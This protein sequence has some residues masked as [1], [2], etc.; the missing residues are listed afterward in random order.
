MDGKHPEKQAFLDTWLS[1]YEMDMFKDLRQWHDCETF[2]ATVRLFTRRDRFKTCSLSGPYEKEMHPMAKVDLAKYLDH[3]K[4]NRKVS[5]SP[6]NAYR[7]QESMG[8]V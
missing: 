2:D 5:G 8:T 6:E 3:A 1:W 4:G 7:L